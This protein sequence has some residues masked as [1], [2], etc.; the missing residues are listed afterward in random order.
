MGKGEKKKMRSEVKARRLIVP[1]I[2]MKILSVDN[3]LM[4]ASQSFV[5]PNFIFFSASVLAL[6][7]L[8]SKL[9]LDIS[10]KVRTLKKKIYHSLDFN[11]F[12]FFWP[13]GC[14]IN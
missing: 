3:L 8:P 6:L 14:D 13:I 11:K 12:H 10:S 5:P 4:T 1:S 7:L 9:N 2:I